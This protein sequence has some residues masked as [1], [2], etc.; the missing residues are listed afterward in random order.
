MSPSRRESRDRPQSTLSEVLEARLLSLPGIRRK[1]SRWGGGLA[2]YVGTREI[3]H[4][5]GSREVD[6]RVTR[7]VARQ[8]RK[9]RS[10]DLRLRF[11][12]SGSDWVATRL[13]EPGDIAFAIQLFEEALRANQ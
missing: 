4:Y 13:E 8:Y 9:L 6:I 5:H 10:P 3:L 12:H 7:E 2:F 1:A 11:R